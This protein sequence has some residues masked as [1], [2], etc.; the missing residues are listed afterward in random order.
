MPAVLLA[1]GTFEACVVSETACGV[2]DDYGPLHNEVR[3]YAMPDG[4]Y[5]VEWDAGDCDGVSIGIWV[6]VAGSKKVRDYDGVFSLPCEVAAF[7]RAQGFDTSEV[8]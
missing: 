6:E 2:R 7:L 3:L 4:H 8:E 5:E 1:T